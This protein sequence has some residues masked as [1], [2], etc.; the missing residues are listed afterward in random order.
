MRKPAV[1]GVSH[2]DMHATGQDRHGRR[3]GLVQETSE[4]VGRPRRSPAR[5]VRVLDKTSPPGHRLVTNHDPD[6]AVT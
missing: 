2:L 5:R 3:V 6:V 4:D 1:H